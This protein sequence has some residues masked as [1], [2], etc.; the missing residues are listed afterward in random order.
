VHVEIAAL[1]SRVGPVPPSTT[2]LLAHVFMG[3]N[4]SDFYFPAGGVLTTQAQSTCIQDDADIMCMI[5]KKNKSN[6]YILSHHA[7]EPLEKSVHLF[8][9]FFGNF[10]FSVT[11][12]FFFF[13][14]F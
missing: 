13:F 6:V 7:T 2:A 8:F 12:F 9:F 10:F 11:N 1:A 3:G 5:R 14:F 4:F